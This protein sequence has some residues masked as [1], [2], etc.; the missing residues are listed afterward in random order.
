MD[1]I[2]PCPSG[3]SPSSNCFLIKLYLEIKIEELNHIEI[4]KISKFY[5]T[6]KEKNS[7]YIILEITVG[8]SCLSQKPAPSNNAR[9]ATA[10]AR[11]FTK[12][13]HS[14]QKTQ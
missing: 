10:S 4:G 1:N 13:Q 8:F 7:Y 5:K 12:T 2:R 11:A 6:Y 14:I 9:S 3:L